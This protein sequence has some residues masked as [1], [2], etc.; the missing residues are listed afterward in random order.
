MNKWKI[1]KLLKAWRLGS[2]FSHLNQAWF[3][4][5]YYFVLAVAKLVWLQFDLYSKKRHEQCRMRLVTCG[6]IKDILT[7]CAAVA[8]CRHRNGLKWL[9]VGRVGLWQVGMCGKDHRR[10]DVGQRHDVFGDLLHLRPVDDAGYDWIH[11]R[12][13]DRLKKLLLTSWKAGRRQHE[14]ERKTAMAKTSGDLLMPSVSLPG[15]IANLVP[16]G[17]WDPRGP[18]SPVVLESCGEATIKP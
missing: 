6:V 1:T 13:S 14:L 12:R 18:I 17:Y 7:L 15:T 9:R 4:L 3:S 5:H 2:S 16:G 10:L 11:C 8:H